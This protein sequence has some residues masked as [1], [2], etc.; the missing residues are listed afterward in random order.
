MVHEKAYNRD[1]THNEKDD[2]PHEKAMVPSCHEL[3]KCVFGNLAVTMV[4]R[5]GVTRENRVSY[6]GP[7][8]LGCSYL[9]RLGL[10]HCTLHLLPRPPWWTL[11]SCMVLALSF[12]VFTDTTIGAK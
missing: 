8:R 11:A 6:T 10:L 7:A 5:G 9:T 4:K 2:K 12:L 1:Q 3:A